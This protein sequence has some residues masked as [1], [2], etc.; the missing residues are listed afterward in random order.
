MRLFAIAV[1]GSAFALSACGE[2]ADQPV[3]TAQVED[4]LGTV[5]E[6]AGDSGD[7][8]RLIGAVGAANLDK[9]LSSEGPFTLFAPTDA[10][11]EKVPAD[12][13]DTLMLEENRAALVNLLTYH[14]VVGA[15]SF[16]ELE[17][18]AADNGGAFQLNTV[19]GMPLVVRV[20]QGTL[21]L[22]DAKGG[23]ANVTTV[24]VEASN[25]LIHVVDKVLMPEE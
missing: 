7:F 19:R 23:K 11:F 17:Q 4:Q 22:E 1:L 24:G 18:K 8:T 15:M 12:T 2:T 6:V 21:T 20:E 16:E 13:L 14:T 9:T 10:A 3:E 25:G 5:L